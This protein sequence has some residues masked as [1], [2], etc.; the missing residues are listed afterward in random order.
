MIPA[1]GPAPRSATPEPGSGRVSRRRRTWAG[2]SVIAAGVVSCGFGITVIAAWY[3]GWTPLLRLAPDAWPV[4]FNTGLGFALTGVALVRMARHCRR[5]A[6]VAGGYDLAVGSLTLLE[7]LTG[8]DLRI[9]QLFA[10]AYLALPGKAPGRVAPNVAVCWSLIGTGILAS[11]LWRRRRRRPALWLALPGA[12]VMALA[13]GAVFGY[14]AGLP[15]AYDWGGLTGMALQTACCMALLGLA[16]M[17]QDWTETRETAQG[18]HWWA[19]PAGLFA[20]VLD[21]FLWLALVTRSEQAAATFPQLI[22]ATAFIGLLLAVV[23]AFTVWLARRAGLAEAQ[24]RALNTELE[25]RVHQRTRDLERATR[26][27]ETFA[28]SVAHDLRAPLRAMSGF[29][30]NLLE[31]HADAL[32]DEG[33]EDARRIQAAAQRMARLIDDVLHLSRVSSAQMRLRSVNLS[34]QVAAIAEELRRRDPE[35]HIQLAITPGVRATADAQLIETAL[36]NLVGNAWKFTSKRDEAVIEFGSIPVPDA[37]VCCYIRDNGAGFD[38]T[39]AS[40]LFQPF[41][42]LHTDREF[43]GTGIGL[44]SARKIIERHEGR[45]WAEGRVD[46]GAIVYFTLN[47]REKDPH[48]VR[49]P[50]AAHSPGRGQRR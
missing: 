38:A 48:G 42:R 47:A 13:V 37:E 7:Y 9:D 31:D 22:K 34:A 18:I 23:L 43:P 25:A 14:A 28:Y 4:M 29:S 44:V 41:Q 36:E 11:T 33:R 12:I 20:L 17:I 10:H 15:S 24:V 27:L 32:N 1:A 26:D 21:V 3:R 40:K 2:T 30:E 8:W 6:V 19:L 45:I 39:Y 35:R 5:F 16:L 46:H 50:D 49:D